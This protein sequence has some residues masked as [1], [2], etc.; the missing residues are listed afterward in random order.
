[1]L[2]FRA[3]DCTIETTTGP[4]T[5]EFRFNDTPGWSFDRAFDAGYRCPSFVWF[6]RSPADCRKG[7]GLGSVNRDYLV[8]AAYLEHFADRLGE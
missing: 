5:E 3:R 6:D 4:V 8:E 2:P 1:M 7:V